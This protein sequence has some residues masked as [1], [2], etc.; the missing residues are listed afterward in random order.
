MRFDSCWC[1]LQ[2]FHSTIYINTS[3]KLSKIYNIAPVTAITKKM[4]DELLMDTLIDKCNHLKCL[5]AGIY[6]ADNFLL[7]L[8]SGKF[9]FASSD[10]ATQK[11]THLILLGNRKH[12]CSFADPL[13][14]PVN[15]YSHISDRL[16]FDC[17]G[18]AEILQAPL[19]NLNSNLCGLCC[20][21]IAH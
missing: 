10:Q 14:F 11:E 19:Q 16:F 2:K 6:A 9:I 1:K 17:S 15:S 20:F 21:H 8:K 5:L 13:G 12:K 3:R 18:V 4:I 7:N